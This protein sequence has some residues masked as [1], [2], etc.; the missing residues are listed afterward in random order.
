MTKTMFLAALFA[1]GAVPGLAA[2]T[3][4]D[5][6]ASAAAPVSS[7]DARAMASK[8]ISAQQK[9][10][11]TLAQACP[12]CHQHGDQQTSN[13]ERPRAGGQR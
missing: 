12:C 4:A 8:Q 2:G 11:T 5:R 6:K 13:S 3:P 9:A 1:L 7:D 10:E